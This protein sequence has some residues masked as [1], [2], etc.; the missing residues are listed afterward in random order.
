[1]TSDQ[2]RPL[3]VLVCS[4]GN[5]AAA[6][7]AA[8]L[9]HGAVADVGPIVVQG[10]GDATPAQDVPR[11]LTEVGLAMGRWR[12]RSVAAAPAVP[13]DVGLTICVPT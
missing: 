7:L 11:V 13:V 5:P 8:G 3:R 12:P 9:L 1:M 6:F 4:S 2:R 10:V